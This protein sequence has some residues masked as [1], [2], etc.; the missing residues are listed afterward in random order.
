MSPESE[1]GPLDLGFRPAQAVLL[2][3]DGQWTMTHILG[4]GAVSALPT[5]TIVHPAESMR[6][7]GSGVWAAQEPMALR[8]R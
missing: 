5:S 2:V 3:P 1:H 7:I 8:R 6:S 4:E